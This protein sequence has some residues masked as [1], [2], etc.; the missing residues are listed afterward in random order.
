[1]RESLSSRIT[2]DP[3]SK[4]EIKKAILSIKLNKAPG[5]DGLMVEIL[6]ADLDTMVEMLHTVLIK[7]WE[8]E[9][10]PEDWNTGCIIPLPKKGDLSVCDN[11]RGITLLRVPSKIL[12]HI[13]MNRLKPVI[14]P[15]I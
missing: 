12:T 3:P 1:M 2:I 8:S 14:E 13:I 10:L 4:G 9:T 11:W 7:V 5:I 6:K 15:S